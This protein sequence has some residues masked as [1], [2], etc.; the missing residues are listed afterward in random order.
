MSHIFP[1]N[2]TP[3]SYDPPLIYSGNHNFSVTNFNKHFFKLV[4]ALRLFSD[5]WLSEP[6]FPKNIYILTIA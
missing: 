3:I 1:Y 5:R 6:P 2:A 4:A